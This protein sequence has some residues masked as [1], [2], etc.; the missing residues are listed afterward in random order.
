MGRFMNDGMVEIDNSRGVRT[1][2]GS[3]PVIPRKSVLMIQFNVRSSHELPPRPEQIYN[4]ATQPTIA[5]I[6]VLTTIPILLYVK[7]SDGE[8]RLEHL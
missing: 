6:G 2:A 8:G 1:R 7:V 4:Y 3:C 5:R